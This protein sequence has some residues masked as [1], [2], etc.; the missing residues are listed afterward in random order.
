MSIEQF[1]VA[2]QARW[3]ALLICVGAVLALVLVATAL[4]PK[5]YAAVS[6]VV[7]DIKSSDP[8]LGMAL[9]QPT[10][11]AAYLAT[12][13][14]VVNSERVAR[15]VV[16]DLKLEEDAGLRRRWEK[17][18]KQ[19]SDFN[20]WLINFLGARITPRASREGNLIN[21]SA[22]WGD[23]E[24]AARLA[25]AVAKAYIDTNLELK[26]EPAKQYAQWFAEQTRTLRDNL[27]QAQL[28]LSKY[29]RDK[30]VIASTERMDVENARLTE[31]S[32]RLIEAQSLRAESS[33]RQRQAAKDA[34]SLPDVIQNPTIATLKA[35]LARLMA[36]RDNTA[37]RLGQNHPDLIRQDSEIAALRERIASESRRVAN[38]VSVTSRINSGREAEIRAA[39]EE[40]RNR[41]LSLT[42]QRDEIAFL[43]ADVANAQRA[44][45]LVTQ[46]LTQTS[47]ES[48]T[49][50]TNVMIIT[51]AMPPDDPASPRLTLNVLV[52]LV[53]GL[54]LGVAVVLILERLDP[55]IRSEADLRNALPLPLLSVVNLR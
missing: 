14:G 43:Q 23:A 37:S 17:S 42:K 49:Q 8:I 18:G 5:K 25:N 20:A 11:A 47:L 24:F 16:S 34:E 54:L 29:Q 21:I 27:E 46:R 51:P 12:Q 3:K 44:Y 10:S 52:G 38:A 50:T 4:M 13:V 41:L 35:E 55:R 28:R 40:Q 15:R 26:V 7:V 31:L 45:D 48:E 36:S 53:L 6:T 33:S 22:E 2:I 39:M 19:G 30:G 32:S 9:T 1:L